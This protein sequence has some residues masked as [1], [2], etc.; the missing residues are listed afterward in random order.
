MV[1]TQPSTFNPHP[2]LL[3]FVLIAYLI[4]GGLF[5]VYTPAW[6]APDEPAHYNYTAQVA[7]NGCCPT[8]EPGDWDSPYLEALKASHFAPEQL[9]NLSAVQYEDHQPPLYYL[10]QAGV[11]RLTNGSLV[12]LRLV[13]VLMGAGIV[14]CAYA[15]GRLVLPE[16]P[17]V[18]LATAALVA[19]LP[20][21]VAILASVNNDALGNLLIAVTMLATFAYLKG[22]DVKIWQ[23]GVLVGLGLL[24]KVSTLFLLGLVPVAIGLKYFTPSQ[25]PP[26]TGEEQEQRR[27]AILQQGVKPALR[28]LV[29]FAIPALV[30]GGVWWARSISV[31]GFPDVFG[32]RQ[33]DLVVADQARTADLIAQVGWGQYLSTAVQTTFNSFWGQ[34]GWMGVPMPG[35]I[36]TVLLGLLLTCLTGYLLPR[37]GEIA[38]IN[39]G[40]RRNLWM[41]MALWGILAVLAY[42]YYNTSFLQLQGRYMFTGL[43]PFALGLALG[44]DGWRRWLAARIPVLQGGWWVYVTVI[45]FILFAVLDL[46]LL[47]RVILPALQIT[48]S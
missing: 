12:A 14:L 46:Y 10:I 26:Y 39:T 37:N 16:H 25:P 33:H 23:L 27:R 45:P 35:W 5:A 15:I 7:Q 24:T 8:I 9:S 28:A 36:Y 43:I 31:Y 30:L 19:F 32:L 4:V 3:A 17:R 38:A 21:H 20:Q 6:Q 2:S 18:A 22:R 42:I 48:S 29:V 1:Q 11:F 41:V 34:F 47:W 44:L 13:S 40:S